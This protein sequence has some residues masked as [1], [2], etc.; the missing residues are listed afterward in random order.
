LASK[1]PFALGKPEEAEEALKTEEQIAGTGVHLGKA[2]CAHVC[3]ICAVLCA[4]MWE[5]R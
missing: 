1:Y 4:R 3:L 5:I 2:R